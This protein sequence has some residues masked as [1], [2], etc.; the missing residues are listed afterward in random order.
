MHER[1]GVVAVDDCVTLRGCGRSTNNSVRSERELLE[2][3]RCG[4]VEAYAG[5]YSLHHDA[6][7]RLARRLCRDR[8]E[9]DDVVSDVF[10]NTLRAINSGHGPRDEARAY[11]LRSVRQTVMKLRTRKDTG[12]ADPMS[13]DELDR[14]CHDEVGHQGGLA[15]E[16]LGGV[17]P[18]FREV[19]WSIEVQGYDTADIAAAE[20]I[21]A[22]AAASLVHRARRA[23]RR[24]Y[25]RSCVRTPESG[26]KCGAVRLLLPALLEND[27]SSS[28]AVRVQLHLDDCEACCGALEE[29][30]NVQ[31]RLLSRSWLLL[32]PSFLRSVVVEGARAVGSIAAVPSVVVLVG[33][34]GATM[35]AVDHSTPE[36]PLATVTLTSGPAPAAVAMGPSD[37]LDHDPTRPIARAT[38]LPTSGAAAGTPSTGPSPDRDG[39]GPSGDHVPGAPILDEVPVLDGDLAGLPAPSAD[40]VLEPIVDGVIS[41]V[42][43]DVVVPVVDL[44]GDSLVGL[45]QQVDQVVDGVGGTVSAGTKDLSDATLGE[46]GA[47]DAVAGEIGAVDEVTDLAHATTTGLGDVL[48]TTVGTTDLSP[49]F[50]AVDAT[51]SSLFG[52]PTG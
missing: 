40:D 15:T 32:A 45:G 51:L 24:S 25:L 49:T 14:P 12:R 20:D 37:T 50:R 8:Y 17:T 36:E 16:A 3:I 38:D 47:V 27:V 1:P 11:L 7:Q 5:L 52:S 29:M 41:P 2:A 31:G 10:C 42:V 39:T 6:V 4:D 26:D 34:T 46:T 30:R 33:L 19:L 9:A 23:L 18:R 22:P 13:N 35:V 28:S 44:A 43:D 48:G 21:A